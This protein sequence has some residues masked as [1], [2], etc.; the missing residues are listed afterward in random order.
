LVSIEPSVNP[1]TVI[2]KTQRLGAGHDLLAH[3]APLAVVHQVEKPHALGKL[4][5]DVLQKGNPLEEGVE[6]EDLQGKP[7][8][9]PLGHLLPA[10]GVEEAVEGEFLQ[11]H[12][13][14]DDVALQ[15]G[16]EAL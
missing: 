13:V 2:G 6:G 11:D 4:P 16:P 9:P 14:K 8:L 15:A 7:P 12:L 10:V 3:I 1:N 5:P